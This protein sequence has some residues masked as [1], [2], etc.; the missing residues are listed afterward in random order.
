MA[1]CFRALQAEGTAE[2]RVPR[3]EGLGTLEEEKVDG[4]VQ[5]TGTAGRRDLARQ[6]RILL[7]SFRLGW[8]GE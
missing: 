1:P 5:S 4:H 2:M 7:R 6:L 8:P 3:Q